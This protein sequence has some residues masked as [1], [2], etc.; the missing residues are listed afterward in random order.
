MMQA[1]DEL[2]KVG[3]EFHD[4]VEEPLWI[5][6]LQKLADADDRNPSLSGYAC[7]ILLE[8]GLIANEALAREVSRRLSPGV[9]ADLAPAGSKAGAAQSLRSAGAADALGA[10]GRVH[11]VARRRAVPPGPGVSPPGVRA[12]QPREKRHIAENLGEYWKLNADVASEMIEQPLTEKEEETLKDLNEFDF[13][14]L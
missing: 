4:R 3:L 1:I 6:Q 14:D 7:A 13:D 12:V 11:R 5:D 10:T 9:P 8:R 2:N